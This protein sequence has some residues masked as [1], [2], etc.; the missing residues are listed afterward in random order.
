[1][2]GRAK[3][4]RG[5]PRGGRTRSR[6]ARCR[7][8]RRPAGLPASPAAGKPRASS[9]RTS[10]SP[11]WTGPAA[12]RLSASAPITRRRLPSSTR[13]PGPRR[14]HARSAPNLKALC[15]HDSGRAADNRPAKAIPS[16]GQP[17]LQPWHRHL[18][19]RRAVALARERPRAA[20]P[21][22]K[23]PATTR[24]AIASCAEDP[25]G[26]RNL[27]GSVEHML[28]RVTKAVLY[29][30]ESFARLESG[31]VSE[32]LAFLL[33]RGLMSPRRALPVPR[34]AR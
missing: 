7:A 6:C 21:R 14:R 31:R 30:G 22:I 5:R 23:L 4:T 24:A 2:C 17:V 11:P 28:H 9:A 25:N 10:A 15:A 1:M 34:R 20:H 29:L 26:H 32:A 12:G 3:T 27:L 8:S 16:I 19:K 18:P 13:T 33:V